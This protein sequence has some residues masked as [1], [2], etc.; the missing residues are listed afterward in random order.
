MWKRKLLHRYAGSDSI[1]CVACNEFVIKDLSGLEDTTQDCVRLTRWIF[2]VGLCAYVVTFVVT[3]F[4]YFFV[5]V[6]LSSNYQ[7]MV[8]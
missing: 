8:K 1:V 7:L 2:C 5:F 6:S 3:S 4:Q